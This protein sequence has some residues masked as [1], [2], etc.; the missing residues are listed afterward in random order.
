MRYL[1]KKKLPFSKVPEDDKNLQDVH[2]GLYNDVIVFDHVEKKA[3]VIHWVRVDHYPSIEMAYCDGKDR[4]DILLSRMVF[5]NGYH[6]DPY[7]KELNLRDWSMLTC[8][9]SL[10]LHLKLKY[11]D[12]GKECLP[13]VGQWN[14]MNKI[15]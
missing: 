9:C 14:M 3:Y 1:E 8:T 2:L 11:H 7:A 15:L 12:T 4:L 10:I 13:Q 6:D 5:Q